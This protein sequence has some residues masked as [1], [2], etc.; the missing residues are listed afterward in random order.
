[1]KL[2]ERNRACTVTYM[3]RKDC[4]KKKTMELATLCR[5]KAYAVCFRSDGAVK[6]WPANSNEVKGEEEFGGIWVRE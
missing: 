4:I 3:K 5:I 6:M 2:M 1:M